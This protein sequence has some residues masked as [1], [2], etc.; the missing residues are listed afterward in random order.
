[1]RPALLGR[2]GG[3]A[4]KRDRK[5]DTHDEMVQYLNY[6]TIEQPYCM[7]AHSAYEVSSENCK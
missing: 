1:M 5:T 2:L 3:V 6:T 7:T 4:L